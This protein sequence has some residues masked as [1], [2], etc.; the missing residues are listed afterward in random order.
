[1]KTLSPVPLAC[2]TWG[3]EELKALQD[4]IDSGRFTMGPKVAEFEKIFADYHDSKYCVMVNSGSSANFLMI[5]ALFF[6]K[7]RKNLNR[8]DEVIVPAVSWS[9]TYSPLHYHGLKVRFVDVDLNT[10]NINIELIEAA[11]TKNTK[12]IFAVNLLG[13]PADYKRLIEICKK[14]DL[15]L[16]EDNCESLGAEYLNKRSGSFGLVSSCSAFFSHHISTMEGGLI[17]TDDEEIYHILLSIRAHGW[18][19]D[20]P[21]KNLICEKNDNAFFESFRFVFP[22]YNVRPLEMSGAIGIAQMK[23]L[24]SLIEKRRDNYYRFRDRMEQFDFIRLQLETGSSSWFGFSMI[25]D[26]SAG[27]SRNNLVS[28]FS[29]RNIECRPIVCGN[30]LENEMISYFDYSVSGDLQASNTIHNRGLFI[31]NH[32]IDIRDGLDNLTEVLKKFKK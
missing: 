18:T 10:L 9:T 15:I 14:H 21:A 12:A 32:H 24:D 29:L 17:L 2:S 30:I 11:I 6:T 13:N 25:V 31:G 20:L 23:K 1:M 22:G 26:E 27:Y 28:C 16:I 8:G 5:A 3:E 7:R 4:V 19:R